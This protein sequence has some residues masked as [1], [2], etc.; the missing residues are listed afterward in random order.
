M[1]DEVLDGHGVTIDVLPDPQGL[2]GV[3][4]DGAPDMLGEFPTPDDA[5]DFAR[6]I[7]TAQPRA[8]VRHVDDDGTVAIEEHYELTS[9]GPLLRRAA[10]RPLRCRG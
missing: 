8:R 10:H 3:W 7:A 6:G 9:G 1:N 5:L 2:W 4:L